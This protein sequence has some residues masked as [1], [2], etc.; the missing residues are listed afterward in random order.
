[1]KTAN[2]TEYERDMVSQSDVV[3]APPRDP[4]AWT[5]PTYNEDKQYKK[6]RSTGSS[7]H[8]A[9]YVLQSYLKNVNNMKAN[10]HLTVGRQ[11]I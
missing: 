8:G 4:E 3:M 2:K 1:M 10:I 9:N 5:N 11:R 7:Q 6:E